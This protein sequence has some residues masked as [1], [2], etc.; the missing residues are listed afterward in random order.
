[1]PFRRFLVIVV[2]VVI[3]A[4]LTVWLGSFALSPFEPDRSFTAVTAVAIAALLTVT[5][6]LRLLTK[7]K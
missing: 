7:A 2:I 5:V 1:M 6:V 4:G 3:M